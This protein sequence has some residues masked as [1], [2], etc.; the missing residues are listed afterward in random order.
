MANVVNIEKCEKMQEE[1][2]AL[3]EE[4]Q[5]GKD[6]MQ[7][8]IDELIGL[9]NVGIANSAKSGYELLELEEN[10]K[11]DH[12][13]WVRFLKYPA[14]APEADAGGK[15]KAPAKGKGAAVEDVKP[16]FGK[17]WLSFNEINKPGATRT[18]QR[19]YLQ[20]CPPITKKANEDG[21]EE[22]VEETEYEPLFETAKTYVHLKFSID[23]PVFPPAST[24][25]PPT[26]QEIIPVKQFVTW[27]YS[28]DPCDDFG[29]QVTLAVESLAKEFYNM[30]KANI[31][32]MRKNT[33][34]TETELSEKF[35]EMKKEFFYEINTQGKYHIMKEKMKKSIV[36][37][38]KE[39]FNRQDP[40]IR[41]VFKD[42]RDHFYSDLYKFLVE[43]MRDTINGLIER[44]KHELHANIMIPK[45]Q[46]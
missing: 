36:R 42:S 7:A 19:V 46:G 17:A 44:K 41:G 18:T 31:Q 26:P 38:V 35:D 4:D 33:Q 40:S 3:P 9:N 25:A 10:V 24:P 6:R 20:T 28:K 29:K 12:G 8:E 39:H 23:Q 27:P 13:C 16:V 11:Y 43:K 45:E 15:G 37:I 34:L 5:D 14:A 30:F 21:T 1:M 32:E 2:A 22:E